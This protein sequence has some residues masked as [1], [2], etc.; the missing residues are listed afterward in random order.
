MI[1]HLLESKIFTLELIDLFMLKRD[2][3][4]KLLKSRKCDNKIEFCNP[5]KISIFGD[6]TSDIKHN[7]LYGVDHV[8]LFRHFN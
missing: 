3:W 8:A 7:N 6:S 1:Q 2:I 4:F 5:M